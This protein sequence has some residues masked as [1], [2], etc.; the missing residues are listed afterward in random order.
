HHLSPNT[1]QIGD[2]IM[3]VNGKDDILHEIGTIGCNESAIFEIRRNNEILEF[4][5]SKN[6]VND[7]TCGIGIALYYYSEII[8]TSVNYSL[9]DTN[10][11][12]PSGGLL[13]AIYVYNELS[14]L[15][16]SHGLRIGGTGTINIDGDV[17]PIGGIKQK[18]ITAIHNHIDIFFVPHLNDAQDDNY[19]EALLT[20]NT[21][22]SDMIIVGVSTFEEAI[23]FLENYGGGN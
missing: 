12:G 20:F 13:Q 1:L 11:G 22:E 9:V 14:D 19:V 10:T 23:L 6:R 16:L 5:V 17:G 4:S 18:I 3:S 7:T 21:F 8:D 15:D 2:Q